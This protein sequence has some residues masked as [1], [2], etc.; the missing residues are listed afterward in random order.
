MNN[1]DE[2]PMNFESKLFYIFGYKV[3][4]NTIYMYHKVRVDS[5][6]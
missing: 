3:K 4:M 5:L 6:P 1:T 2:N